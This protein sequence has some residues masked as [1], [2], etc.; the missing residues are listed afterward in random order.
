[1]RDASGM[2]DRTEARAASFPPRPSLCVGDTKRVHRS[3]TGL[4]SSMAKHPK[5][6]CT[7]TRSLLRDR[8]IRW[9]RL[10]TLASR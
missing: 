9:N 8:G 7:L 6:D 1:M 5:Q 4:I 10:T 3:G 2:I